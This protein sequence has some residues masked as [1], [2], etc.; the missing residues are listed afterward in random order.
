MNHVTALVGPCRCWKAPEVI[1]ILR[2]YK[3]FPCDVQRLC[4]ASDGS[5]DNVEPQIIPTDGLQSQ[6]IPF[7]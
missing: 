7:K 6:M 4:R 1:N 2:V 3:G 5:D